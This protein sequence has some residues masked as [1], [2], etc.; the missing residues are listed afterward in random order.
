[1]VKLGDKAKDVV[2]GLEGIVIS[3]SQALFGCD[4]VYIQPSVDKDGKQRDGFWVDIDSVKIVK[5]GA[6][7]GHVERKPSEK[8]GG[9]MSR[10]R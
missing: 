10:I 8:T 6:V 4:R 5:V 3:T 7:K 2:T 1:M 9:P